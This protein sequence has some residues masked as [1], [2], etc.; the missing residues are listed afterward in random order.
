MNHS[1]GVYWYSATIFKNQQG[2]CQV[3][4]PFSLLLASVV[5]GVRGEYTFVTISISGIIFICINA[6]GAMHFSKGVVR[7]GDYYT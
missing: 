2:P 4:G 6:P 1:M 7:G 3:H 5:S